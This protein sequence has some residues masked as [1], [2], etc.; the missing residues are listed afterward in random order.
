VKTYR[1]FNDYPVA[2]FS[3]EISTIS[4]DSVVVLLMPLQARDVPDCKFYSPARTG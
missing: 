3:M 2:L 1:D 4:W